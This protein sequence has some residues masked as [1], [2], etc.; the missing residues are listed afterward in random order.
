MT[1]SISP[2]GLNEEEYAQLLSAVGHHAEV[3]DADAWGEQED[4]L[5]VTNSLFILLVARRDWR[6]LSLAQDEWEILQGALEHHEEV[7]SDAVLTEDDPQPWLGIY[8]A[9]RSLRAKIGT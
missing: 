6:I 1:N 9:T 3:L 8:Q 4:E 5:Q 7:Y 2:V